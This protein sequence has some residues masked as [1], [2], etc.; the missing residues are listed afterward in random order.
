MNLGE[1]KNHDRLSPVLAKGHT[2]G[3]T[4][5]TFTMCSDDADSM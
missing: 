3:T 2:I 4:I 5:K 1:F